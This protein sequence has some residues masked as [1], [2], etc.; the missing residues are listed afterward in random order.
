MK[1][2]TLKTQLFLALMVA[3]TILLAPAAFAAAPGITTT[4][5]TAGT[6]T[7]NLTA[8]DAYLNQPDGNAVY[9]WGYGCATGSSPTFTPNPS[10]FAFPPTCNTMQVPGPTMIVTEG[11]TVIVNLT[12]QLPTPAGNTSILFPGFNVVTSCSA[13]TPVGQ[14]GLL[15]CEAPPGATVTYTFTASA[16]G[17][18]AYY[19]GTQGDLQVEMG[20]YGAIIV[21][22]ATVPT[23]CNSTVTNLYGKTT[24]LSSVGIAEEHDFRLAHAAYDHPKSCYDR[25]YL[26][27]WAE[28]DARIHQQAMAQVQAKLGCSA[29]AMGCSLD[30][31]TEPYHPAYFLINGRSMPDLMDPEYAGEYPHQPYNGNPHMHPGELTLIRTIG[32]GR[33]QHPFHE[34]AN[35]VRI[36]ARDGNLIL[37]PNNP[38]S[39][40][41]GSLMFNTDTTP[42]EAF[43]GIFYFSGRGLNW[44]PYGHHPA[45][46]GTGTTQLP[47]TR[48][49]E[50]GDTVTVT[51]AGNQIPAPGGS[52]VIG[53]VTPSGYDGTFT[54][55]TS[56]AG[57]T[58]NT[59]TFTD[60]KPET[61]T[62]SNITETGTTVTVT[63]PT[64]LPT[65]IVGAQVRIAGVTPAGYDGT[66]TVA[67]VTGTHF[68][69]TDASGLGAATR[70]SAT[71]TLSATYGL[72][73][74]TSGTV[75][76]DLGANSAPNDPLASLPCTPDANGYNTGNPA[77]LN[78]YEWC[79]D[80]N[81]PVQVAPFGDVAS[82]GP[83]SLPDPNVF[84][85]GQWYGGSPYFGPDASLRGSMPACDTTVN[86]NCTT[87]LPS[88]T[89]A[90]PANERG[91]AFMWHS[92]NER[93][94]TTN[95]VFP[96]G[97]LMMML[98]DSREFAIDESQ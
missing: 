76:M 58:S 30:V 91:W 39:S 53:S 52:V 10:Y 94:I 70:T 27:Q 67:T 13:S 50:S 59:I 49:S 29:G 46:T 38:T 37:S 64:A 11:Q 5:G 90:N 62:I 36:L 34:H 45:G 78:Y 6:G 61:L 43:D 86:A 47:I 83:A 28:M 73:A 95:N 81:K 56:T 4:G 25:E 82:G 80:H 32:Q 41:A 24:Y 44:D 51:F 16:P 22:P 79:Q 87:L 17:T 18:H 89:Q 3:V 98:V 66:F 68:T 75:T 57:T 20:L 96:G 92:H 14:Q 54:I 63:T 40:L 55:L 84:T 19:S 12:N 7:F 85:N 60:T 71:A 1:N 33:W 74:A 88:N 9:S 77:A 72:A 31:Q 2:A 69:Y 97:M 26:F 65:S 8:Q 93:E 21:L 35:H 15:T 48:I 23:S 42:G